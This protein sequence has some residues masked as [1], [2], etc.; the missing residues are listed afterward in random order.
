MLSFYLSSYFHDNVANMHSQVCDNAKYGLFL[1]S[2][3]ADTKSSVSSRTSTSLKMPVGSSS[4]PTK[5]SSAAPSYTEDD[6][7]DF[8]PRGTSSASKHLQYFLQ[9]NFYFARMC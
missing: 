3:V 6:F 4:V 5:S 1:F 9:I 8:D 7:D 2:K